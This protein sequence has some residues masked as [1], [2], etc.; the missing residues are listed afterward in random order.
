M[1]YMVIFLNEEVFNILE[2]RERKKKN[3]ILTN[4]HFCVRARDDIFYSQR[5]WKNKRTSE[6]HKND[7]YYIVIK[8]T[9]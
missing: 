2:R 3:K 1:I 7:I 8:K 6:I 5:V 9:I 4:N